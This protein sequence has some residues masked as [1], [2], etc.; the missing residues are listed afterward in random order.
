MVARL[1]NIIVVLRKAGEKLVPEYTQIL[2]DVNAK[3][4]NKEF[5]KVEH[6]IL[7]RQNFT[8]LKYYVANTSLNS[9]YMLVN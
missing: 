2:R 8:S 4:F 6:Q 7:F 3:N 1:Q 9:Y 5:K